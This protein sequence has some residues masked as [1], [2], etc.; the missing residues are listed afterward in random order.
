MR[1]NKRFVFVCDKAERE[2]I[3]ALATHLRR[4]QG[5]A[6]RF[7]IVEE[8]KKLLNGAPDAIPA[9]QDVIERATT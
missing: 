2:L 1:K 8:A 5:D 4:S 3:A 7:V 9:L 6:I